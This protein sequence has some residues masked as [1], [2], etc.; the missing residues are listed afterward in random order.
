MLLDKILPDVCRTLGC[1]VQVTNDD[2][3]QL[4]GRILSVSEDQK[5]VKIRNLNS[6]REELVS[7]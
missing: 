7:V 2:S 5:A 6:Y 4:F 1:I 3:S